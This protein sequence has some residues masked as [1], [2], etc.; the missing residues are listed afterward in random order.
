MF[1]DFRIYCYSKCSSRP[2]LFSFPFSFPLK[3]DDTF[4]MKSTLSRYLFTINLE[5][6]EKP[7]RLRGGP[8]RLKEG[9]YQCLLT[10]A[11]R[12]LRIFITRV[13]PHNGQNVWAWLKPW[14]NA[15]RQA[16]LDIVFTVIVT[17]SSDAEFFPALLPADKKTIA[18]EV[19]KAE[20]RYKCRLFRHQCLKNRTQSAFAS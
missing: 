17:T 7:G 5:K 10:A 8:S 20:T 16:C 3:N 14:A 4:S 12:F 18:G 6:K 11:F 9:L 15:L 1:Y 2:L 13:V 19:L